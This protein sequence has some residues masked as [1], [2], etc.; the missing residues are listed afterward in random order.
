M[1][2][3]IYDV[4]IVGAGPA[5]ST[6]AKFIA[7]EGFKVLLIDKEKFP[8]NKPCGG[9]LTRRVIERFPYMSKILQNI[10]TSE[11]IFDGKIYSPSLKYSAKIISN[12]PLGFMV[13]RDQFDYE[14]VKIAKNAGAEF[15]DTFH[16]SDV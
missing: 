2:Q 16:I 8:R 13:F 1:T 10:I 6:A 3:E 12:K 9:A 11:K 7:E 4:I 15:Y 14:L 5:G